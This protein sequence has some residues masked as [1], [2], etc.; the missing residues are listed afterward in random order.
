[1]IKLPKPI[2]FGQNIAPIQ[3]PRVSQLQDTYLDKNV[4]VSGFGRTSDNATTIS[5]DL[6]FVNMKVISNAEC[7]RIFGLR[8]VTSSV[9]CSKGLEKNKNA[10]LGGN[11]NMINWILQNV[12]LFV[13]TVSS[14]SL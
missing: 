4:Q 6:N 3:L 10:C 14:E 2:P 7:S 5:H 8:I 12:I 9:I 1:M 13:F 11:I